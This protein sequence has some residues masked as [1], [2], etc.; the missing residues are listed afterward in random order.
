MD[1]HAADHHAPNDVG[2]H[3]AALPLGGADRDAVRALAQALR[4]EVVAGRVHDVRALGSALA[5]DA[6]TSRTDG[7]RS[8]V[9]LDDAA[10]AS[11]LVEV[12]DAVVA[13][14]PHASS[15]ERRDA[16]RA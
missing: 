16:I 1:R 4:Q 13:G 12:L 11:D 8:V 5:A 6:A 2:E 9:V 7:H 15:R 10:S 14:R 3:A